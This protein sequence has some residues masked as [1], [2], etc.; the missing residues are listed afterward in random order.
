MF[1]VEPCSAI[2][3]RVDTETEDI[4]EFVRISDNESKLYC[5]MPKKFVDS[6]LDKIKNMEVYEDDIWIVTFPKCGTTWTQEMLWLIKNDLNY[7][8]AKAKDLSLRSSFLE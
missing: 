5:V 6:C 7:E 3:K 1:T 8:E 4:S 2:D